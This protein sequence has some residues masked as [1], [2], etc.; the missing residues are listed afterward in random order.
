[1]SGVA[2]MRVVL[3]VQE[4]SKSYKLY[5]SPSDRLLELI[6]GRTRHQLHWALRDVNLCVRRGQCFGVVGD[7]GA[8]KSTLL[9]LIAGALRPTEG[10]I[11]PAGRITAILELGAGFHP[12]FS[13]RENLYFSGAI[14]GIPARQM[15]ALE[16]DIIDF[17]ELHEAIDRPV[18]TYSSGM[19][20]RLAFA[21]VTA[22][23]P[24]ILIVDEALAVGD[25]HFQKKC[26][27]RIKQ[28]R[29]NGCAI[30]FCSHSLYHVRKLCD[31][32]IW[33]HE[34]RVRASGDVEPVLAGYE[35][36]VRALDAPEAADTQATPTARPPAPPGRAA[37]IAVEVAGLDAGDPP[38]LVDKDLRVTVTAQADL[39]QAPSIA[40]MLE[41]ADGVC[42]TAV[43]N[44]ADHVVPRRIGDG[45]WQSTVCFP[46][47]P[48]YSGEYVVSAYLFDGD[49]VLVYDEWLRYRSFMVVYPTLEIG[50]VRLRHEWS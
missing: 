28:F 5:R 35:N 47:L 1:M 21:L 2:D 3:D 9:K 23:E 6:G 41:R 4:L 20:V 43:G 8:G 30:L 44:H 18:K 34:G 13:G 16:T 11:R 39:D 19:V 46:D 42:V 25:Q 40:V 36:H 12:D 48:L 31:Q 15:Q 33:L 26:S 32:A 24:D 37:L 49:G 38:R 29:R 17:A 10:A 14:I 7:N 22:V 27:E 45:K 50:L